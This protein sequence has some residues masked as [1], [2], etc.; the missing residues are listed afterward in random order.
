MPIKFRQ[1]F[2]DV[3]K[4]NPR[5]IIDL[6]KSHLI[7]HAIRILEKYRLLG[8]LMPFVALGLT[9]S[10]LPNKV[11]WAVFIGSGGILVFSIFCKFK[12]NRK[13]DYKC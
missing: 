9:L 8:V 13:G 4:R 2:F 3:F 5:A 10:I 1:R 11:I 12:P 6:T 7:I